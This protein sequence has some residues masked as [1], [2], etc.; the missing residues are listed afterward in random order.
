MF[1]LKYD[2]KSNVTFHIFEGGIENKDKKY[3]CMLQLQQ[4][5]QLNKQRNKCTNKKC[6]LFCELENMV[7]KTGTSMYSLTEFIKTQNLK[8][9]I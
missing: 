9:L 3:A 2:N 1:I 5:Q 8:K 7:T 4:Q 6:K